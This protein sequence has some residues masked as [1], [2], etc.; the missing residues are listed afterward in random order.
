[1]K[2]WEALIGAALTLNIMYHPI[3]TASQKYSYQITKDFIF[4][5]HP[6]SDIIYNPEYA[7]IVKRISLSP[8]SQ[9]S[10]LLTKLVERYNITCRGVEER[11]KNYSSIEYFTYVFYQKKSHSL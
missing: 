9:A 10:T 7:Q 8:L 5:A 4:R 6:R 2:G 11:R 3:N 1:M